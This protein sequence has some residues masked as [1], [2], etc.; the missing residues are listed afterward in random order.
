MVCDSLYE[1][2]EPIVFRMFDP[3]LAKPIGWSLDNHNLGKSHLLT[4][5][6][7]KMTSAKQTTIWIGLTFVQNGDTM[8]KNA[9]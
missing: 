2:C 6:F 4:C 8:M 3:S 1:S 7:T 9:S 5:F